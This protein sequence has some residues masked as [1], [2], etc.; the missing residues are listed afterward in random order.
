MEQKRNLEEGKVTS[1]RPTTPITPSLWNWPVRPGIF[2][3]LLPC[4]GSSCNRDPK[5]TYCST[6]NR[7]TRCAPQQKNNQLI[8]LNLQWQESLHCLHSS[9]AHHNL[10]QGLRYPAAVTEVTVPLPGSYAVHR[11]RQLHISF[12]KTSPLFPTPSNGSCPCIKTGA[13]ALTVLWPM[14][15]HWLPSRTPSNSS[16]TR[17]PWPCHY[18]GNR[19]T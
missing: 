18:P 4:S 9:P 2:E 6:L 15:S 19:V 5:V 1:R 7:E 14:R 3:L 12:S 16:L 10:E 11:L 13:T 8:C 17:C